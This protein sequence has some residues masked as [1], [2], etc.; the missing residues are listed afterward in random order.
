MLML[1]TG[2]LFGLF[3]SLHCLGMCAPI[4]WAIPVRTGSRF[5]WWKL[6]LS[7]NFG[8]IITYSL[9]GS[10]FGLA[11]HSVR[12]MGFQQHLSIITG[13]FLLFFL[14]INKGRIPSGFRLKPLSRLLLRVKASLS[15]LMNGNTAKTNALLGFY[16]GLLPC[17]LVYMALIASLSMGSVQGGMLYMISFG[18]GTLPM[19]IAA[20]WMG[21]SLRSL[22][23]SMV[24]R[25][26]PRFIVLVAL[27]LIVRGL[28]L[29]IPYISPKLVKGQAIEL[30]E[31][32]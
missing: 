26:I 22:N 3:G 32:P 18:L 23:Q 16:N 11:G 4:V 5:H 27:L 24:R 21:R 30:C 1:W 17:G 7:Y 8:R 28:N 31:Q 13:V 9:L 29:G 6:R 19:M 10:L 20:A 14:L 2:F 12:L 15:R 25:W